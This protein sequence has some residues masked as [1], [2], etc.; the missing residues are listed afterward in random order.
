MRRPLT[1]RMVV[2]VYDRVVTV[3]PKAS[4]PYMPGYGIVGPT[5]GS[6]LL[7]WSW[8]VER[9]AGSRNYWV[10]TRWPD[11]RPHAMPVWGLWEQ[12][13]FWF[14][15]SLG[16]RKARN[17]NADPRC[18]VT[19][20]SAQEPVVLEGTAEIVTN[21]QALERMLA[22]ENAKYKTSYGIEML[23]PAKNATIRVVP[24]WAF[25]LDAADFTGSPT[26]WAF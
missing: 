22:L 17:L 1:A 15:S 20:E 5:E 26:R 25:A 4:R 21:P 16:S 9:L 18:T 19:T 23:D 13:A 14:S 10:V 7:P 12:D 3:E 6:G 2:R 11:G 8:A 24:R